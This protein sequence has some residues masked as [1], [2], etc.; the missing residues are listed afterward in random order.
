M[1][2]Y[3]MLLFAAVWPGIAAAGL[4]VTDLV[5][6]AETEGKKVIAVLA[7]LADGTQLALD[8]GARMVAVDL[9]SGREFVLRGPGRYRVDKDGPSAVQGVAVESAALPIKNL[10]SIR[11]APAGVAQAALVMRGIRKTSGLVLE[12]PVRTAVLTTTPKLRWLPVEGATGYRVVISDDRGAQL[13]EAMAAEPEFTL[14]APAG[15]AHGKRYKW[16]VEALGQQGSFADAAAEFS[17]LSTETAER[18]AQLKPEAGAPYAR[19]ILYATLLQ[20]AGVR[21]EAKALWKSLAEERPG[22]ELITE[23]AK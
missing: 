14:P 19:R 17:V 18:L 6:K 8:G 11:I 20:E 1:K 4:L 13:F 15:L 7:E 22:N 9:V 3:M 12:S 21:D 5:G 2:H 10:A 23:L 16:R